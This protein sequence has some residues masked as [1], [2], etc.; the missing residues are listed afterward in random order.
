M[1]VAFKDY[2]RD[3]IKTANQDFGF[4]AG[5]PGHV[6]TYQDFCQ[7]WRGLQHKGNPT[8]EKWIDRIV[9]RF[10]LDPSGLFP[11]W[12]ER[13]QVLKTR[14][15]EH[16]LEVLIYTPE[17]PDE[18]QAKTPAN[19]QALYQANDT[20][21]LQKRQRTAGDAGIERIRKDIILDTY[22][23]AL[24][25]EKCRVTCQELDRQFTELNLEKTDRLLNDGWVKPS[26]MAAW[27]D[28]FTK[29][30]VKGYFAMTCRRN[31]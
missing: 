28:E 19:A 23:N 2:L 16:F 27:E 15:P 30:K 22:P 21:K 31:G 4:Y 14:S 9:S 12:D 11:L 8:L 7:S 25:G 17:Y 24:K 13:K 18:W 10:I 6:L 29:Q 26:Y 1:P 3:L 5:Q 20:L